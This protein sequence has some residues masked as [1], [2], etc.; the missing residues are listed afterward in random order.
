MTRRRIAHCCTGP[1]RAVNFHRRPHPPKQSLWSRVIGPKGTL[2]RRG[3]SL[4]GSSSEGKDGKNS[5]QENPVARLKLL[6]L[7]SFL[8]LHMLNLSA[9]LT[10]PLRAPS[11]AVA[12]TTPLD[13]SLLALLTPTQVHSSASDDESAEPRLRVR[14]SPPLMLRPARPLS[15]RRVLSLHIN[16]VL[17]AW[18]RLVGDPVLSKGIVVVLAISVLPNAYLIR[19]VGRAGACASGTGERRRR[20]TQRRRRR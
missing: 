20:S 10:S 2:L 14:L 17:S 16:T 7:A 18:T 15:R 1:V 5:A 6:L 9:P 8:G 12:H 13:R 11:A 4:T 3:S 19:G